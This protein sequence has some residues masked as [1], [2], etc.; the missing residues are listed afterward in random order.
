[1]NQFPNKDADKST[2]ED[3]DFQLPVKKTA[4][5]TCFCRSGGGGKSF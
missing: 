4:M 5:R 1:M 2:E 3:S